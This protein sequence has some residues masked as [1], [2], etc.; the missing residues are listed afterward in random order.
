MDIYLYLAKFPI[1]GNISQFLIRLDTL[2]A[3]I[4]Y[5]LV[6]TSFHCKHLTKLNV[7]D[8]DMYIYIFFCLGGGVGIYNNIAWK[9]DRQKS[10]LK[11]LCWSVKAFHHWHDVSFFIA[12]FEHVWPCHMFNPI[13]DGYFWGCSLM[14]G[15]EKNPSFL[16][17]VTPIL[18]WWNL[19][20]LYL[21]YRHQ[22]FFI[23]NQ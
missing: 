14:G 4:Q 23:R 6:L 1:S 3:S 20:Q 10:K 7:N 11:K 8:N 9:E 16:K 19:A 22:H 18:Q 5:V 12:N 21:T 15:G 17:S 2:P 13:Q